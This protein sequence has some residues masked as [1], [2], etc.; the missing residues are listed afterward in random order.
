MKRTSRSL[1]PF[2]LAALLIWLSACAPAVT[3][4]PSPAAPSA[5]SQEQEADPPGIVEVEKLA[6][7]EVQ[8]PG[9]LPEGVSLESAAFETEP[10]P[11]VALYYKLVHEQFGDR[12]RFFQIRQEPLSEPPPAVPSCGEEPEGCEVLQAGERQ[13]I[14]HRYPSPTGDGADTESLEWYAD[15]FFFLLHRTAGEPGV[16]YRDE[17]LKVASSIR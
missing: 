7:F 3:Y 14:Y 11:G 8:L 16:L 4:A 1:L 5:P 13:F 10:A 15:G 9:Y 2:S 12:G 17:L 6:G